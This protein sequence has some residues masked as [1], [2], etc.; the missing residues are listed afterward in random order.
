MGCS[1]RVFCASVATFSSV[2]NPTESNDAPIMTGS[3]FPPRFPPIHNFALLTEGIWIEYRWTRI[4]EIVG[5]GEPFVRR[6]EDDC[7]IRARR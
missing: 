4:E 7:A 3:A 5:H 1:Q 2:D 6:E